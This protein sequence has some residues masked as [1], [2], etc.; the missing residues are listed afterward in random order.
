[1]ILLRPDVLSIFQRQHGLAALDQLL[2]TGVSRSSID[3]A[4]GRGAIE[5]LLPG[6]FILTGTELTFSAKCIAAL[7]YFG[8]NAYLFGKTAAALHGCRGVG[9]ETVHVR[10]PANAHVH[11]LPRWLKARRSV[12]RLDGDVVTIA[13]GLRVSSPLRTL[14]D[15]ASLVNQYRFDRIAEDLWHLKLVTP[16]AAS[17]YLEHARRSGRRG[18]ARFEAW[19]ERTM[20]RPL[21]AQSGLE[22]DLIDEIVGAGLPEPV[23]QHPLIL[24]SGELIHIDVAWPHIQFGLEPGHSWWH[25]GDLQVRKDYARDNACGE[26]GWFIRRL[27]EEQCADR[28][29]T[30]RLVK[31]LYD[32]RTAT[33]WPVG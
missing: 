30:A 12:W 20:D 19:V 25:G 22:L 27:D 6:V 11:E 21:P 29:E 33:F 5:T 28:R 2:A 8:P 32:S 18:V 24:A 9:R 14:F 13:H 26:L 1:V 16:P 31:S 17:V 10:V 7:L 3:R 4:R 23:R 15:M